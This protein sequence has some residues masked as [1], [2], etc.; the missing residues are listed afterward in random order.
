M[1][2]ES[3]DS[4][5]GW[6]RSVQGNAPGMLE[7]PDQELSDQQVLPDARHGI[8]SNM[9]TEGRMQQ[10]PLQY[11]AF[12]TYNPGHGLMYQQQFP[13]PPSLRPQDQIYNSVNNGDAAA[14]YYRLP[15][16]AQQ[17]HNISRGYDVPCVHGGLHHCSGGPVGTEPVATSPTMRRVA[18]EA[19]V[20]AAERRRVNPHRFFCEYCDR[21]FTAMHNYK[22]HMGAHNDERPF[23][24]YCGSAFTTRSDLKRHQHKSKKHAEDIDPQLATIR[25]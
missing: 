16:G 2:H 17:H 8:S 9:N 6:D 10:Y 22:R 5:R 20:D 11:Y 19:V 25:E 24:C 23:D 12:D 1:T 4:Q 14:H 3:Q 18:T 7:Y 13:V 21:G 15:Q